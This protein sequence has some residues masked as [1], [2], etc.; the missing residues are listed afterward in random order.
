MAHSTASTEIATTAVRNGAKLITHLFNA[1]PQLHHRDPS[2]IGLL[3]ASPHLTSPFPSLYSTPEVV[4]T[5]DALT[6][7]GSEAFD[8]VATPTWTPMHHADALSS[9]SRSPLHL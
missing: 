8:E 2:I 4:H 1:M 6:V 3:S 9:G 7:P 5:E